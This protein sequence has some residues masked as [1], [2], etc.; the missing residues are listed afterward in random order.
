VI[1]CM[2]AAAINFVKRERHHFQSGQYPDYTRSAS[3]QVWGGVDRPLAGNP[4]STAAE[5]DR[6]D[7]PERSYRGKISSPTPAVRG[8][9][10]AVEASTPNTGSAAFLAR[11]GPVTGAPT[12]VPQRSDFFAVKVIYVSSNSWKGS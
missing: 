8:G 3:H 9:L 1:V 5:Q 7:H 10:G 12:T 11:D 6:D 2:R 4:K